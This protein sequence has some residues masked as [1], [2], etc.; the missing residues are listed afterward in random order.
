MRVNVHQLAIC[1]LVMTILIQDLSSNG[2]GG[3]EAGKRCKKCKKCKKKGCIVVG[4]PIILKKNPKPKYHHW[5][6]RKFPS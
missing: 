3:V 5:Y 4:K 6:D 2:G 1:I